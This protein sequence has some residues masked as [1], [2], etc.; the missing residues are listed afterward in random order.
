[1]HAGLFGYVGEGAVVVVVVE[2]VLSIIGDKDVGPAVVV[3]VGDGH[4]VPQRSLV[5]PALAA[6]SVK[7]PSWLLRKRA[8]WGGVAL[9]V[10]R[11]HG[12]AV[13]HINVE[14]AVVVVV[15]QAHARALWSR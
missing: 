2:P 14:P 9:P 4:A 8:A 1:V 13:H 10:Q 11:V 6:T 15:D 7:V 3:V 12:R 5:T